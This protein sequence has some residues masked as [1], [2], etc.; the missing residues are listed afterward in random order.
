MPVLSALLAGALGFWG[1]SQL[2]DLRHGAEPVLP[3]PPPPD[4][5]VTPPETHASPGRA[6][7]PAQAI[8]A[9]ARG[10][11]TASGAIVPAA[12]ATPA[13][14]ARE[15]EALRARVAELEHK[16]EVARQLETAEWGEP[17]QAPSDLDERFDQDVL[18]ANF[19]AALKAAGFADAH[20]TSVDCTEYPC[21]LYGEGMGSREDFSKLASTEDLAPYRG[22][23]RMAWGFYSAGTDG[24]SPK[25]R[26]GVAYYPE[27]TSKEAK[28]AMSKRLDYRFRQMKATFGP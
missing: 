20:V 24:G 17:I 25:P 23:D 4:T 8:P 7:A 27:Q 1:G 22:D 19:E 3:S 26:F 2:G 18:R 28:A 21:I 9:G 15:N 5:P 6:I 13:A 10:P 14:L 16:L 12:A 11:D